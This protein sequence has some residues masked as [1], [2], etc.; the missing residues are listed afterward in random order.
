M[1]GQKRDP[2]AFSSKKDPPVTPQKKLRTRVDIKVLK[3]AEELLPEAF[4]ESLCASGIWVEDMGRYSVVKCYPEN[5]KTFLKMIKALHVPAEDILVTDEPERD[6]AELSKKYF[7][8]I[9]VEGLT[10]LTP[11]NKTRRDGPRILIE[12]GMA[13][14]T[15]RHESTR[16]MI[17]LMSGMNMEGKSVLD[18]GCGSAILS[19]YAALLEAGHVLAVDVD[20]DAVASARKN[21]A[22]NRAAVDITCCDLQQVTGGYDIVLANID[23]ATFRGM[24]AHIIDLLN[25]GGYLLVS[26][27]LRRNKEELL[28]L[29]APLSCLNAELK[30]SWCGFVFQKDAHGATTRRN[31]HTSS[32][33]SYPGS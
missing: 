10:I 31:L 1:T 17:K 25:K 7:R 9:R 26:G 23:I 14:G 3:G 13:F 21:I 16:L 28:S 22:L 5:V 33:D 2:M 30:N 27:V 15:G 24:S 11:W 20:E 4:Y 8:P 32:T 18:L 19:L 29:F 6:Y 12:P